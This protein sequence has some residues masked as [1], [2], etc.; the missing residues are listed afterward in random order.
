MNRSRLL[1]LGLAIGMISALPL[2]NAAACQDP[3]LF[4]PQNR[5]S[6]GDPVNF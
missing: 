3:N 1:K 6:P 4:V 5:V 2:A